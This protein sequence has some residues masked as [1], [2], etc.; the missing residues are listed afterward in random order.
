MTETYLSLSQTNG[1]NESNM[2]GTPILNQLG[3]H[4]LEFLSLFK[5]HIGTQ[6]Y[7]KLNRRNFRSCKL[8]KNYFVQIMDFMNYAVR[9][10]TY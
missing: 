7:D 2:M 1:S 10:N 6:S 5:S 8:E 4:W 3:S 9:I